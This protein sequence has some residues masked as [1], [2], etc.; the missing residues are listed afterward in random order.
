M[1]RLVGILCC[2]FLLIA[3]AVWALEKCHG[4]AAH[5]DGHEHSENVAQ[6][7]THGLNLPGDQTLAADAVIHCVSSGEIPSFISQPSPRIT[8]LD[9]T[10]SVLTSSFVAVMA[11][12]SGWIT[13]SQK[14]PPGWFL[15]AVSAY[16][17]LSVLRV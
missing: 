12:A 3:G 4:L 5:H 8:R 6:A 7:H 11:E 13:Y 10:H 14:R 16:L 2:L 9:V 15:A 17:S 1:K